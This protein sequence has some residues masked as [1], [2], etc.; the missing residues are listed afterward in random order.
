MVDFRLR[1]KI[2]GVGGVWVAQVGLV[3]AQ[4]WSDLAHVEVALAQVR[5]LVAR[6]EVV[7]AQVRAV[8]AR[9]KAVPAQVYDPLVRVQ[10]ILLK[11]FD[12]NQK[13]TITK[14]NKEGFRQPPKIIILNRLSMGE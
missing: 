12:K 13:S 11:V 6:V 4:D 5:A 9:V 14:N 10:T 1:P 2:V 7:L 3:A 8:L